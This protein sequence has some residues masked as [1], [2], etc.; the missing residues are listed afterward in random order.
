MDEFT[1]E[2]AP[3][4][5]RGMLYLL[6]SLILV[7]TIIAGYIFASK[8]QT[9][10]TVMEDIPTN[11][12]QTT[13]QLSPAPATGTVMSPTATQPMVIEIEG[14]EYYFK[15]DTI[16]VKKDTPVKI[17][18]NNSGGDH[19]FVIDEFNVQSDEIADGET[20]VVEFTPD[21]VGEFEYYCSVGEHR[22]NGMFGALIV[23]E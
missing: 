5:N 4:K 7:V 16:T 17:T 3:S 21:R 6:I 2:Y 22:A 13:E 20:T 1:Q 15:P 11:V 10:S 8:S 19:D 18:F 14:G 23:T 12:V 9:D